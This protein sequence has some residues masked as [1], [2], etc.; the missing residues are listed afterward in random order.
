MG[1]PVCRMLSPTLEQEAVFNEEQSSCESWTVGIGATSASK[2]VS[3]LMEGRPRSRPR[4]EVAMMGSA[5]DPGEL[6]ARCN[7]SRAI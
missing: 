3:G 2:I 7:D 4:F 6:Q 5:G 1:T